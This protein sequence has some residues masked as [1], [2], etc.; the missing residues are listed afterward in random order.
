MNW[1]P[2]PYPDPQA[3]ST[4]GEFFLRNGVAQATRY[5]SCVIVALGGYRVHRYG[6]PA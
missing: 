5:G 4:A 6:Q 1:H 2:Y 3:S